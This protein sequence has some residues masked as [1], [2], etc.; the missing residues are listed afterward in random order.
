MPERE[1]A[2]FVL[3][4]ITDEGAYNNIVLRKTLNAHPELTKVQK[5][6]V[7]QLVNGTLRNM[8]HIDYIINQF[9]KTPVKKIK[10]L[11]LNCLRT[12]IY[13]IMY[14]DKIPVSAACNE[15]VNTAKRHGFKSLSGF[16][17]GIL[18]NVARNKDNIKYPDNNSKEYISIK[19]SYP[20][21]IIDYWCEDHSM[22]KVKKICKANSTPPRITICVNTIKTTKADLA[23]SLRAE[24]IE[25]DENTNLDNTLYIS[26]MNNIAETKCY[27]EG[28]FHI[29]D[30]SSVIAVKALAPKE[31]STIVD[32]CAAPGGKSFACACAMNNKGEI[33]SRDIY[34]HKAELMAEGSKRLG[35]NI[36]KPQVKDALKEDIIKA[37]YVIV[38]A[39]CS[40][41][42]LVRKK[43]DI[44]YNK[45]PEDIS[46]LSKLQRDILK[47]CQSMVNDNGVLLYST[48]TISHKENIDNINW[49]CKNFDFECEDL[50]PY[51]P[52]GLNINTI[53]TGCIEITPDLLGSDGFFIAR[54]RRKK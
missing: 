54:L 29:M 52:E 37:D 50:T 49:F 5:A 3:A 35:L 40:G 41:L 10:P 34:P 23:R 38:D 33:L 21:W 31:G 25:V 9:S 44:K 51:I 6:F 7:T 47:S 36:I 4:D 48:C 53:K 28:L 17:N 13:Q 22:N 8:L 11:I 45:S 14:M 46:A 15:A 42:G 32:V 24:D 39:P 30:E 2:V 1:I 16:V 26:K 18:R 27:K 12:G 19:Y 20:Q 43:P